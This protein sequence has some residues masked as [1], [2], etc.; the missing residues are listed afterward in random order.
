MFTWII[1]AMKRKLDLHKLKLAVEEYF[2][3]R[4]DVG[5]LLER[6]R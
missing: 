3:G 2:L 5:D 4:K 6:C 1:S